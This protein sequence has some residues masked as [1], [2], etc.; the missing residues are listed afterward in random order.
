MALLSGLQGGRAL[1][2][3]LLEAGTGHSW[4]Q[5]RAELS[6]G[7]WWGLQLLPW[8]APECSGK[9]PML[10]GGHSWAGAEGEH[11]RVGVG[12][13][14]GALPGWDGLSREESWLA[15]SVLGAMS[16]QKLLLLREPHVCLSQ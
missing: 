11:L 10:P 2:C 1:G 6:F 15:G 16:F 14:K 8:K 12:R 7:E 5:V 9:L 4:D 3:G 13:D